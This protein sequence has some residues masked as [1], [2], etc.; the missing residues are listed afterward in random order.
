MA[1]K[2]T[3]TER[4]TLLA[5]LKNRFDKNKQRHKGIN[6]NDVQT[7]LEAH[8]GKLW[9]LLQM[10]ETGGEPDVIGKDK[11]TNEIVFCDCT[12]ETPKERRNVCYDNA[13]LEARKEHKP[14]DSA[15]TMA[16]AMGISLLTE[17]EYRELQEIGAFDLKTSSWLLTPEH[18]RKLG[19]A[20][21]GD[22]RYDHVFIYHNG[23]SSYY[24][25]RGFR[26]KLKV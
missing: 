16:E 10:E 9:S 26:G 3:A 15:M 22:R 13:A 24:S 2:L 1:N 11:K 5:T 4:E 21:F 19:G 23:A 14:S 18:I 17:Q 12:V 6:W 25:V 20:L 7:R 8:P